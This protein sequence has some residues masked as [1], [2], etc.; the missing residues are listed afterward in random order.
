MSAQSSGLEHVTTVPV[1]LST[2]RNAG[3]SSLSPSRIP[4]R[5]APVCD[6]GPVS[7]SIRR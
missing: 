2:Q 6:D 4:A 1:A 7:H 3:M 5:L